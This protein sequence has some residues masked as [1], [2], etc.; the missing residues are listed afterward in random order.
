[1]MAFCSIKVKKLGSKRVNVFST[2]GSDTTFTNELKDTYQ[3]IL[4]STTVARSR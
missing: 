3:I 4:E 2:C 1:M